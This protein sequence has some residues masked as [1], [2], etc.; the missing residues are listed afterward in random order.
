MRITKAIVAA[1]FALSALTMGTAAQAGDHDRDWRRDYREARYDRYD[2]DDRYDRYDHDRG[3]HYGWDRGRYYGW[4]HHRR[5]WTEWH[6]HHRVTV[7][8]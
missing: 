1:G 6:W 5:C 2:H 3:R 7:C 8:R 4:D